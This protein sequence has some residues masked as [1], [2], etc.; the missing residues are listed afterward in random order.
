MKRCIFPAGI[1][2]VAPY[3]PGVYVEATK[4]L[5]I[6]GQ[7]G[8]LPD[9]PTGKALASTIEEQ[10][11]LALKNMGKVLAEVGLS[12]EN[13]VSVEVLLSDMSFFGQV[14]GVYGKYFPK[15]P[16]SRAA[17]AVK[18][19]PLNALVEIKGIAVKFD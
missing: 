13:L 17:Y 8:F 15:D 2:P 5:Y 10:T 14:N 16:P 11:D 1:R 9:D 12:F 19:L 4:T 6:S 7:L 18:G 3:S